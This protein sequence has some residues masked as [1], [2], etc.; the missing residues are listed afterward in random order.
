LSP[1]G[2][3][4]AH[5]EVTVDGGDIWVR[6]LE[7]RRTFRVTN[8]P[9]GELRPTWTP[10]GLSVAFITDQRNPRSLF[11][12]RADGVGPAE[13][14]LDIEEPVNDARWS[15]SGD[16]LVYRTGRSTPL[17]VYARRMRGGD[18][19]IAVA[20]DPEIEEHSPSLSPDERWIAYVSDETGRQ[21]VYVRPFPDVAVAKHQVSVG[22]GTMPRWAHSGKELFFKS[23]D[24]LMTVSIRTVPSFFASEPRRL[25]SFDGY[26]IPGGVELYGGVYDVAPDDQRFVMVRLPD[27]A[28]SDDNRAPVMVLVQNF[29]EEVTTKF[30]N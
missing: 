6:D 1:D 25:F 4:L 8:A 30:G 26:D 28:A 20:T 10:D 22:G 17:D 12:K 24:Y 18:T 13:L 23:G 5:S 16:W 19:T 14:V 15:K 27:E 29:F 11:R 7:A 2:T 9:V 21:Q 3:K